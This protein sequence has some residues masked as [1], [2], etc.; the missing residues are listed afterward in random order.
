MIRQEQRKQRVDEHAEAIAKAFKKV[1]ADGRTRTRAFRRHERHLIR[2]TFG[3]SPDTS[4]DD[5]GEETG[6]LSRGEEAG[7][8]EDETG[9]L[10]VG[11][12]AGDGGEEAEVFSSGEE[13]RDGGEETDVLSG[14]K[15]AED[16]G[17]E[18]SASDDRRGEEEDGSEYMEEDAGEDEEDAGD[19]EESENAA[20]EDTEVPPN[21]H[22]RRAGE[23]K[24]PA[25][26]LF[27]NFPT[28]FGNWQDFH[29]VFQA[30]QVKK[31]QHFSKRTSTSVTVRNNQIK[32]A[33][34]RLKRQGKKQRK[35]EQFLPEE[36]GQYSKTLVCTHGQ[37]Y[38]S[39][40]KGRRK[41][42]KVR[43]TECSARVN[44]RVKATLDDSWVLR[45]TVSGSH[46][47]D[48]NEHVWEEYSGNRTVKDAGLQ[49]D[50]E[51]LRKAGATAKGILQ[52]LRE[53]TGKCVLLFNF[54][55]TG[56]TLV[57]LWYIW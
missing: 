37:P 12:E 6:V 57:H 32:R 30:Y 13:A 26:S 54:G 39:R 22:R 24:T 3:I 34:L 7:D 28:T 50:V 25:L 27:K 31:Y 55:I 40:G 43:G 45:V 38:H 35:K 44:A 4:D 21:F 15:E 53:R 11:E 52:Y 47:H 9:V 16:G 1:Q 5:A 8:G 14:G 20:S 10:S 48:L 51:V 46:N 36:W 2:Q 49:Q 17:E 56:L 33:A 41:H 19:E 18:S 29:E 23:K 42:E